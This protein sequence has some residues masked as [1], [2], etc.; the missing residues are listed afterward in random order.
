MDAF[1]I[2]LILFFTWFIYAY[3]SF[4]ECEIFIDGR[5]YVDTST[6]SNSGYGVFTRGFIPKDTVIE[7]AHTI[8]VP[9]DERKYMSTIVKYDFSKIDDNDTLVAMGF[10]GMYNNHK[11]YNVDWTSTHKNVIFK[12]NQDVY[13]GQEL[14]ITYGP[15]YFK[16]HEMHEEE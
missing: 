9:E 13:P 15:D 1:T 8:L 3:F 12:T 16:L 2:F 14:F 6:L 11:N 7:V 10:G 5:L 4:K